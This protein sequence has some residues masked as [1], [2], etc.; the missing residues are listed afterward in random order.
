MV[1]AIIGISLQRASLVAIFLIIWNQNIL[2]SATTEPINRLY[3]ALRL[4]SL[5]AFVLMVIFIWKKSLFDSLETSFP[6]NSAFHVALVRY[7]GMGF[8][9]TNQVEDAES[10]TFEFTIDE[11]KSFEFE[12]MV[13]AIYT[14]TLMWVYHLQSKIS[15]LERQKVDLILVKNF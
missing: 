8:V 10:E 5:N 14:V 9:L 12:T 3:W 4:I 13:F 2:L 11:R 7:E 6:D 15:I 1:L